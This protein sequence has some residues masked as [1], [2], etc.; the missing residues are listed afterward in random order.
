MRDTKDKLEQNAQEKDWKIRKED[1]QQKH[2]KG[3][4][5]RE[6]RWKVRKP[7]APKD[8]NRIGSDVTGDKSVLGSFSRVCHRLS[9]RAGGCIFVTRAIANAFASSQLLAS[10]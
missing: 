1:W 7:A 8:K 4:L 6:Q 10:I 9:Y 5:V 3:T 2:C